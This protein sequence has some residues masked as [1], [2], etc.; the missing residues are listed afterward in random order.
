MRRTLSLFLKLVAPLFLVV[1]MLHLVLGLGADAMLG[2]QVSPTSAAEPTLDSQNRFYG[3]SFAFY[4]IALLV[5]AGD[6]RRYQPVLRALFYVL[7]A[8]GLA[9]L[10]SWMAYGTPAPPVVALGAV[11]VLGPPV[12]LFWLDRATRE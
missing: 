8:A 12:L 9:R 7:M 5:C 1:A 3:V 2:A 10:V 6:L 4:G 11:E